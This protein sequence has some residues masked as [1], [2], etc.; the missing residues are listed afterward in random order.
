M[1]LNINGGTRGVEKNGSSSRWLNRLG[2]FVQM[3]QK[4]LSWKTHNGRAINLHFPL[5]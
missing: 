5:F 2:A 4:F 3:E 1:P